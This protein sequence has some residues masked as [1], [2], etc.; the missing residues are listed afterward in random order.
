MTLEGKL[1]LVDPNEPDPKSTAFTL[2]P[3]GR[4]TRVFRV[5]EGPDVQLV[6]EN[7]RFLV[8]KDGHTITGLAGPAGK[9]PR[10]R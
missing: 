4:A 1:V 10:I 3:V 6:G 8:G 9:L 7:V 2:E 5:A